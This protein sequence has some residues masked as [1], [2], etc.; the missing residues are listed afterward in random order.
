MVNH[1][2]NS[3]IQSADDS[4]TIQSVANTG[5]KLLKTL[6]TISWLYDYV[7]NNLNNCYPN[8]QFWNINV[9]TNI[10]GP[11]SFICY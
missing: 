11:K 6:N 1:I 10:T 2:L 8:I 5:K 9:F 4:A 3:P 7:Y